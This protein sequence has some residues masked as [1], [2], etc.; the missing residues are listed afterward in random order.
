[1]KAAAR[2]FRKVLKGQHIQT[3][4]VINVDKNAAYPVA[5][6]TLQVD[7]TVAEETELRQSKYLNNVIE[8]DHRNIKRIVKPMMGFKTFNSARRTLSGIEAMNEYDSERTSERSQQRGQYISSKIYRSE[9]RNCCL[10]E[11]DQ[12]RSFVIN[13][14]LRHNRLSYQRDPL[15]H[16]LKYLLYLAPRSSLPC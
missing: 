10:R 13:K 9:L 6:Q 12:Y 3:P 2:F 5:M 11:C 16:S 8:Q 14:F 4:R 7:E 15:T 1:M